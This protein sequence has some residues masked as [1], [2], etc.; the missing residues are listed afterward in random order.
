MNRPQS[1][2]RDLNQRVAV[3]TGASRGLGRAI[4]V[5]MGRRGAIVIVNHKSDRPPPRP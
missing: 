1:P 3:V 2:T 4:A 5:E